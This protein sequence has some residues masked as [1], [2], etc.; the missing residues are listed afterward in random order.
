MCSL[1]FLLL[2]A[3]VHPF[4]ATSGEMQW[5]AET[6]CVEVALRID[7][8]DERWLKEQAKRR[9]GQAN[10]PAKWELSCL[11]QHLLF[12]PKPKTPSKEKPGAFESRPLRWVGQKEEGAYVWWFFEVVCEDGIPP[13]KLRT[14][15]LFKRDRAFQHRFVV[16]S[17]AEDESKKAFD[18]S[19]QK[20][21][22]T[23]SLL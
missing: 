19:E 22:A 15:L 1:L 13:R 8:L 7:V 16:L 23:F 9:S 10:A 5:N 17:E 21:E 14:S 20:P 2:G 18:L 4:H 11:K 12:D 6:G 3:M